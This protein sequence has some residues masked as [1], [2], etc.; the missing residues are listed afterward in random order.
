MIYESH[1]LKSQ[2][3]KLTPLPHSTPLYAWLDKMGTIVFFWNLVKLEKMW[4]FLIKC[5]EENMYNEKSISPSS[6]PCWTPWLTYVE[7]SLLTLT[8]LY[9]NQPSTVPLIPITWLSLSSN[10]LW[11]ILSNA[12]LG[13]SRMSTEPMRRWALVFKYCLSGSFPGSL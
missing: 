9:V 1:I 2:R 13:F 12:T 3:E 11:L 7:R 4:Y 6:D 10:I 8:N 5:P